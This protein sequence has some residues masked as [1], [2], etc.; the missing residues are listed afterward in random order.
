MYLAIEFMDAG[1]GVRLTT[2]GKVPGGLLIDAHRIFA[3][4]HL[5]AFARADYWFSDHS[6]LEA[7]LL[8]HAHARSVAT[9]DTR[10]AVANPDLVVGN[11]VP[12]DL[13]F[14]MAR[15]WQALAEQTGWQVGTHRNEDS[16]QAFF[17][18]TLGKRVDLHGP[19][20]APP[21]VLFEDG[22]DSMS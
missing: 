20:D 7:V 17:E 16:L 1:R 12:G 5:E 6:A 3:D 8:D 22:E 4:E 10:L 19:A 11:L 2:R 15:T 13:E 21:V 9:I 18:Q 14:G